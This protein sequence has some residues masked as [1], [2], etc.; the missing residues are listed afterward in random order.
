M[1]EGLGIAIS[2]LG[3]CKRL[4]LTYLTVDLNPKPQTLNHSQTS[5]RRTTIWGFGL[6]VT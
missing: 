6:W 3:G 4:A 5:L 2:I 1:N